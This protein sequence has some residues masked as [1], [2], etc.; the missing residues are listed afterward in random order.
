MLSLVQVVL[1][2]GFSRNSKAT[3]IASDLIERNK[4]DVTVK[5][6][7]FETLGDRGAGELLEIGRAHV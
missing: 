2:E 6:G 4:T 3:G 7:V 5:G 1:V